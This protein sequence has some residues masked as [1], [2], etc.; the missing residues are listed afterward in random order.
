MALV[1]VPLRW[2]WGR[3]G[4]GPIG[5]DSQAADS[6]RVC[7]LLWFSPQ[8]P[9]YSARWLLTTISCLVIPDQRGLVLFFG[10]LLA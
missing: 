8:A 3:R 6:V 5:R 2:L 9:Q 4:L 10:S 1:P 7:A